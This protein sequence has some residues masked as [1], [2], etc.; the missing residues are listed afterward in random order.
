MQPHER[1]KSK[2]APQVRASAKNLYSPTNRPIESKIW[3]FVHEHVSPGYSIKP[4]AFRLDVYTGKHTFGLR[5]STYEGL[6]LGTQEER[7]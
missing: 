6:G 2:S 1:L 3:G 5:V 7:S 4:L